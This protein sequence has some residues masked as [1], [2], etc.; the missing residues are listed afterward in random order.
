MSELFRC[1][2]C[3]EKRDEVVFTTAGRIGGSNPDLPVIVC[4]ECLDR[5]DE[6]NAAE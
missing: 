4:E 2:L 6:M 3:E 1:V 5:V